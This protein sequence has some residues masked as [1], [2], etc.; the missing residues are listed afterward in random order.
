[1]QN[2]YSH[3]GYRHSL[4][5]ISSIVVMLIIEMLNWKSDFSFYPHRAITIDGGSYCDSWLYLLAERH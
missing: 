2:F 4:L 1:M 3:R 5:A